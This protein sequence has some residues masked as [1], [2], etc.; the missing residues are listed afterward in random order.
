VANL[1]ELNEEKLKKLLEL[2]S[3]VQPWHTNLSKGVKPTIER[4]ETYYL[5]PDRLRVERSTKPEKHQ[6]KKLASF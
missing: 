2:H 5:S 3:K 1:Q 4:I 6:K